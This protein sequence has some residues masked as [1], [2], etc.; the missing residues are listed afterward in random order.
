MKHFFILAF[1]FFA[2]S[3]MVIA[4]QEDSVSIRFAD[5]EV[6]PT[7]PGGDVALMEFVYNN[8]NYPSRAMNKGIEGR[9]F[10]QF[11]IGADGVVRDVIVAKGVDKSLDKEAVRVVSLLPAWTPG[12]HNGKKVPVIFVVP[13]NFRL[14]YD[15]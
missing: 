10:V 1:I 15:D 13:I 3:S 8:C 11:T 14:Y 9:V 4:Q 6:K 12:M 5:V 2:F 7:F